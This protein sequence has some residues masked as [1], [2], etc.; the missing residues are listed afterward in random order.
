MVA[1]RIVQ[2]AEEV[3]G[4]EHVLPHA[5]HTTGQ[6]GRLQHL[7]LCSRQ[8]QARCYLAQL[9]TSIKRRVV[10]LLL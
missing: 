7:K 6:L 4:R 9:M 2:L 3:G 5:L 8:A 1:A 10:R